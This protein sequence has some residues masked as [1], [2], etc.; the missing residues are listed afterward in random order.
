MASIILESLLLSTVPLL[1]EGILSRDSKLSLL[2]DM[3][4]AR[5][6][7]TET[8]TETDGVDMLDDLICRSTQVYPLFWSTR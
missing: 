1:A 2:V 3:F 5:E 7:E 6:Y 4:S 8:E